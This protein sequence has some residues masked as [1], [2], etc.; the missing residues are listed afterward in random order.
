[1]RRVLLVAFLAS[2]CVGSMTR[3]PKQIPA[4][5]VVDCTDTMEAP[6]AAAAVAVASAASLAYAMSNME[7]SINNGGILWMPVLGMTS[8]YGMIGAAEGHSRATEC[9]AA[10]RHGA[11]R[12]ELA[13]RREADANARVEAGRLWKRAAAAARAED[14]A[15][16]RELDPQIR[17]LDLEFHGVVFARDVAIARCLATR[18]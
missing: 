11:E 1:M 6:I 9:G 3:A 15:T 8:A 16:V 5:G 2:A 14:C 10:K 12:A 13:R 4:D 18:S 17:E 7:D